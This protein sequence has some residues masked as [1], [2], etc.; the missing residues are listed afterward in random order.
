MLTFKMSTF[1]QHLPQESGLASCVVEFL[2][3]S[4]LC[5]FTCSLL[6]TLILTILLSVL[7]KTLGPS[8]QNTLSL[9][10]H[11]DQE[12][13]KKNLS[14]LALTSICLNAA[15]AVH[16][17]KLL[18]LQPTP[19]Q[20]ANLQKGV[21]FQSNKTYLVMHLMTRIYRLRISACADLLLHRQSLESLSVGTVRPLSLPDLNLHVPSQSS[22]QDCEN[23]LHPQLFLSSNPS[24]PHPRPQNLS[25]HTA[26]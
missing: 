21:S 11:L 17:R 19:R 10:L 23:L 26:T 18:H 4:Q 12:L 15:E 20:A 13:V 5:A 16:H 2:Q 24:C 9:R 22:V 6:I 25:A 1:H 3:A 7:W 14:P 8:L